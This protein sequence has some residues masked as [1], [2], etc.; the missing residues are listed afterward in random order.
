MSTQPIWWIVC[1]MWRDLSWETGRGWLFFCYRTVVRSKVITVK[2]WMCYN[3]SQ[4]HDWLIRSC[5]RGRGGT[6]RSDDMH[7]QT[8]SPGSATCWE[9]S[10]PQKGVDRQI[11]DPSVV[12][13]CFVSPH[14]DED[15]F[16]TIDLDFLCCIRTWVWRLRKSKNKTGDGSP[17][18]SSLCCHSCWPR[19]T[20]TTRML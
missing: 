14:M 4:N 9:N 13:V 19:C 6:D 11:N 7:H 2:I 18:I 15:V 3:S 17:H 5:V 20:N 12:W 16:R 10:W 1:G 8:S